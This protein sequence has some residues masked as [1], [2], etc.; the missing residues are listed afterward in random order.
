M[1]AKGGVVF[2]SVVEAFIKLVVGVILAAVFLAVGWL[3][4]KTIA[5]EL[6][7]A[8]SGSG[9]QTGLGILAGAVVIGA[10]I[11]VGATMLS[12]RK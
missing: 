7:S 1:A 10:S 2:P 8:F 11:V 6:V 9:G 4:F 5:N 12:L 3:A